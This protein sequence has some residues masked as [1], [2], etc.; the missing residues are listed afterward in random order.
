[1]SRRGWWFPSQLCENLKCHIASIEFA[2]NWLQQQNNPLKPR[3]EAE[4]RCVNECGLNQA[5]IVNLPFGESMPSADVPQCAQM[6]KDINYECTCCFF[7]ASLSKL[8]LKS[9][10][11]EMFVDFDRLPPAAC[12]LFWLLTGFHCWFRVAALHLFKKTKNKTKTLLYKL[13]PPSSTQGEFICECTRRVRLELVPII[14]SH[15]SW[16]TALLISVWFK[17]CCFNSGDYAHLS[18]GSHDFTLTYASYHTHTFLV[19]EIRSAL[20]RGCPWRRNRIGAQDLILP[21]PLL[22]HHLNTS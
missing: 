19:N 17:P 8:S 13:S 14:S 15:F 10:D 4:K 20:R 6:I 3:W 18:P 7:G 2:P 5:T 16:S 11:Q 1:M 22:L 9:G 21:P 12:F